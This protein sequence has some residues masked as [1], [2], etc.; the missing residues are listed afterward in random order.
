MLLPVGF[1]LVFC[2]VIGL[3]NL[4]DA[5]VLKNR[6]LASRFTS[7][8]FNKPV[9]I[10]FEPSGKTVVASQ[11]DILADV[12]AKNGVYIPYKCK[13]GR[14]NSCELRLNGRVSAKACQKAAVPAGPTKTLFV[15]VVNTKPL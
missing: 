11:G 1:I 15:A 6:A 2:L 8:I 9:T 3:L 4:S 10:T 5:Y 14:C 7:K 13:Q 12:A